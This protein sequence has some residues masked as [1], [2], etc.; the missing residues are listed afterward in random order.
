MGL[1]QQTKSTMGEG[2]RKTFQSSLGWRSLLLVCV[3][4]RSRFGCLVQLAKI[5]IHRDT[6][7][8][9]DLMNRTIAL[10]DDSGNQLLGDF[11][12]ALDGIGGW[13]C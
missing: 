2:G 5:A 1:P 13:R 4:R 12:G 6:A 10:T 8:L 7:V 9:R 11:N 3:C